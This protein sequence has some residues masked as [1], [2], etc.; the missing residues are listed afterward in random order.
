MSLNVKCPSCGQAQRLSDEVLGQKVAC[1]SCGAGFR[2]AAPKP[3]AGTDPAKATSRARPLAASDAPPAPPRAPGG[4][5]ES[6]AAP[7][8]VGVRATASAK[9]GGLLRWVFAAAAGGAVVV[10]AVAVV[11][12]SFGGSAASRYPD[13]ALDVAWARRRFRGPRAAQPAAAPAPLA[14]NA[15]PLSRSVASAANPS[16]AAAPS[17]PAAESAAAPAG[18][19]PVAAASPGENAR[20]TTAQIVARWEPS[21][22]LIKGQAFFGTGFLVKQGVVATNA[23]VIFDEF[24]SNLE[25]RFPSAPAGKQGPFAVELLYEDNKRDLAFLGVK[26]DLPATEV[27]PTYTFVKGDDITV[28]GNP[29]LGGDIVLENAVTRGVVSS[30]TVIDGMNFIQLSISI[31]PGNSGGPIFDS[32]GRVIG[33]ATLKAAKGDALAFS[34]PVEDLKAALAGVGAAARIWSRSTAPVLPSGC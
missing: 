1:P 13:P 3:A 10:I 30:K 32:S 5:A 6:I 12:R 4:A 2:V 14:A 21:V 26:T 27:V 24:I 11:I 18:S 19:A 33:V 8:T 22:A 20:L 25:V 23:H 28:I 31:N 7:K 29:G 16:P 17:T 34:I 15:T 9:R